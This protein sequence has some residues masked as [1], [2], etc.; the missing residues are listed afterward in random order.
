MN[1]PMLESL[2]K[3]TGI[4]GLPSLASQVPS[5]ECKYQSAAL[6]HPS[7]STLLTPEWYA[8]DASLASNAHHGSRLPLSQGTATAKDNYELRAGIQPRLSESHYALLQTLFPDGDPGTPKTQY[9]REPLAAH[10]A[11]SSVTVMP[12]AP[13]TFTELEP[14]TLV[15]DLLETQNEISGLKGSLATLLARMDYARDVRSSATMTKRASA[16]SEEAR[17]VSVLRSLLKDMERMSALTVRL[18]AAVQSELIR[19]A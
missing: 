7:T 5:T 19:S 6:A 8:P 9:V 3:D 13:L 14:G 10:A 11:D 17:A 2:R 12:K 15:H 18:T 16:R 1:I 4:I